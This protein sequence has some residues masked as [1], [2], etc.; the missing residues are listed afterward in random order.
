MKKAFFIIF[1]LILAAF[2]VFCSFWRGEKIDFLRTSQSPAAEVSVSPTPSSV[3]NVLPFQK[4]AE[5]EVF[6][7]PVFNYHHIRP[8]PS[9]ASSTINERAFIVSPEMLEEHIKY[10]LDN[11]YKIV[12]VSDLIKYYDTG[13]PLPKKAV[14]LSF[15]DGYLEHYQNAFPILKKYNVKATFFIPTG[16]VSSAEHLGNLTWPEIQEM[17]RAGMEFGSHAV[18]HSNLTKLSDEALKKELEESKKILEE[19]IGRPCDILSY[20]GGNYDERVIE[21]VKIAGYQGAGTVYKIIEQA[22]KYRFTIRRF[23]ADDNME[24]V[25]G[26]LIGY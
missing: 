3:K 9:V 21:A 25:A 23:H 18:F 20:P 2:A 17:S 4:P 26:K 7:F 19:K 6:K 1:I 16:W 12:P 24:S 8:M 15:D 22:P 13:A 14:A 10:F 5:D 11:D